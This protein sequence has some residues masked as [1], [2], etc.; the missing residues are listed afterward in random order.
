MVKNGNKRTSNRHQKAREGLLPLPFLFYDALNFVCMAFSLRNG[1][2]NHPNNKKSLKADFKG[3]KRGLLSFLFCLHYTPNS[4]PIHTP[5]FTPYPQTQK[6]TQRERS[7]QK[8]C[9]TRV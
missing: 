8:P 9:V 6:N 5:I 7:L 4:T 3:L 1:V 2:V